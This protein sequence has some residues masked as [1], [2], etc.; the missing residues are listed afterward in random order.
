MYAKGLDTPGLF[1]TS[2]ASWEVQSLTSHIQNGK[3]YV[4]SDVHAIAETMKNYI[5]R[6]SYMLND[7][8]PPIFAKVPIDA[9]DSTDNVMEDLLTF[10]LSEQELALIGWIIDLLTIVSCSEKTQLNARGIATIMAPNLMAGEEDPAVITSFVSYLCAMIA[11]R[12]VV[13][14]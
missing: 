14:N 7:S 4:C 12:S 10:G 6:Y 5:R 2:G 3:Y 9:F 11:V 13:K 8:M 1:R